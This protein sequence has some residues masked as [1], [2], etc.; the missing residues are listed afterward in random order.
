M[1]SPPDDETLLLEL[2]QAFYRAFAG[3]DAGQ[4]ATIWAKVAP[5]C[6]IHPGWPP[7][8]GRDAVLE[9]WRRILQNPAQPP[10]EMLAPRVTLWGD[11]AL[12]TCFERV[13]GQYLIASNLFVREGKGW[14]LSHHQ[15]GPVATPPPGGA[16]NDESDPDLD[17][18]DDMDDDDE[19]DDDDLPP[20]SGTIH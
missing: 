12:V 16:S 8:F 1:A 10:V 9:G 3:R 6:C 13:D 7:L 4:M 2:N 17:D 14:K 19:D 18:L 5:V 15:A 11:V 20:G